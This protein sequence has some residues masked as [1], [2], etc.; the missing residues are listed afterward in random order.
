MGG[1]LENVENLMFP[2]KEDQKKELDLA[3]S[4]ECGNCNCK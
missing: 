1:F 3:N 2:D 4:C